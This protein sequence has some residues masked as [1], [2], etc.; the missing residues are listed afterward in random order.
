MHYRMRG[1]EGREYGEVSVA[2]Y[3]CY[4]ATRTTMSLKKK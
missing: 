1:L 4:I 3:A 2:F